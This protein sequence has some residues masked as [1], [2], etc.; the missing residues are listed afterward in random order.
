MGTS[1]DKERWLGVIRIGPLQ[2][3]KDVEHQ[4][5]CQAQQRKVQKITIER[6]KV[7]QNA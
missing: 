3:A 6:N 1:R 4:Q 7:L 2:R 5:R